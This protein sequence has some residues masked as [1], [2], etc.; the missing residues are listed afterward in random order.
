[1]KGALHKGL[2]ALLALG[3]V[4]PTLAADGQRVLQP[5]SVW[6]M[7]YAE[8]SC[9]LSRLFGPEAERVLLSLEQYSP[10]EGFRL[11]IGSDAFAI[12]QEGVAVA[13]GPEGRVQSEYI[14]RG[15]LGDFDRAIFVSTGLLPSEQKLKV[16]SAKAAFDWRDHVPTPSD[17]AHTAT[18]EAAIEWLE[19]RGRRD[20]IRLALGSMGPPMA[21]LHT[22][23]DEL[24][25][26]WGIDVQAHKTLQRAVVPKTNPG[27]WI[28]A[29]DYPTGLLVRGYQGYVRFRLAVNEQG[30]PSSCHIQRSTRPVGFDEVVC[31]KL[32]RKAD[33]MP[34]LDK[35]GQ[36]IPS[37]WVSAVFFELP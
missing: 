1:M 8:D 2:V 28:T 6:K 20:P 19:V 21:A 33:F 37:Y 3:T 16:T 22:C 34:A 23:T 24:L 35:D 4:S 18:K 29:N 11:S 25:G 31:D 30:K 27:R 36:P 14:Q 9:R 32:M 13:F 12:D 17:K 10:G 7:D 26:H 15:S 5:V